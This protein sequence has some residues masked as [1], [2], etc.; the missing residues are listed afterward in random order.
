MDDTVIRADSN[1]MSAIGLTPPC[2][3][4]ISLQLTPL[5]LQGVFTAP[6]GIARPQVADEIEQRFE[7]VTADSLQ[8]VALQLWGCARRQPPVTVKYKLAL[9]IYYTGKSN[10]E[11][12][13]CEH[14]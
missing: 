11:H 5:R 2:H 14:T 6:H 7:E 10:I 3:P 13:S 4:V 8:R 9:A 1:H 12:S